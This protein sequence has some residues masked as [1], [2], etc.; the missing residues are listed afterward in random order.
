MPKGLPY[1]YDP[2][3]P[4]PSHVHQGQDWEAVKGTP[5]WFREAGTIVWAQDTGQLGNYIAIQTDRDPTVSRGL[6]HASK[7]LV[8]VGQHVKAGETVGLSGGVPGEPGAGLTTGPHWHEEE[9][10]GA[11]LFNSGENRVDP[12]A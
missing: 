11:T 4:T 5:G 7:M 9:R 6:A 12:Y 3:Y 2:T 8:T 1:G 10:H